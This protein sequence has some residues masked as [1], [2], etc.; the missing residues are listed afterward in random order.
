MQP[1]AACGKK[2]FPHFLPPFPK[3][4]YINRPKQIFSPNKILGH[5]LC[6]FTIVP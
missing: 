6:P 1:P 3:P 5:A 2:F 4:T